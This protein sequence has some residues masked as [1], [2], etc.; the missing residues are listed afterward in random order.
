MIDLAHIWHRVK[1]A[2]S[3]AIS[4]IL[5]TFKEKP[6]HDK[7]FTKAELLVSANTTATRRAQQRA[8]QA[9]RTKF[10]SK[11]IEDELHQL[12]QVYPKQVAQAV[13]NQRGETMDHSRNWLKAQADALGKN[14]KERKKLRRKLLAEQQ[15]QLAA[16]EVQP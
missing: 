7:D 3:E 15:R 14:K 9:A 2:W 1:L 5:A 12:A 4:Y 13:A 8:E 10:V 6:V 11:P 16:M